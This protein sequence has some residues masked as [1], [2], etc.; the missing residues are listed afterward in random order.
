MP[1]TPRIPSLL[2][3]MSLFSATACSAA[4]SDDT[5]RPL[6]SAGDSSTGSGPDSASEAGR[7]DTTTQASETGNSNDDMPPRVEIESPMA[8]GFVSSRVVHI[9]G[10]AEDDEALAEV[11]LRV[12]DSPWQAVSVDANAQWSTAITLSRG[13]HRVQVVARDTH[14]NE[15]LA[16]VDLGLGS[17]VAGGGAHSLAVDEDGVVWAWG[18]HNEGQ[19]G[20]GDAGDQTRPVPVPGLENVVS[21][22]ANLN[23]SVALTDTGAVFVWGSND[24]SQLG[25]EGQGDQLRPTALEMLSNI[26]LI[27]A[28]QR[29]TVAVDAEGGV[30]AWGSNE[31][32]QLGVA[33]ITFAPAPVQIE[34]LPPVI[35]I[36]AGAGHTIAVAQDGAVWTW[37]R[38]DDGQLARDASEP[39]AVAGLVATNVAAGKSHSLALAQAGRAWGWGLQS[40]GQV[41]NGEAD[42]GGIVRPTSLVGLDA[43]AGVS[44][45]GNSS[46]ALDGTGVLWAWGDN[47]SGQLGVGDRADRFEPTAVQIPAPVVAVDQGIAHTVARDAQGGVWAWGLNSFGQVGSGDSGN[48]HDVPVRIELR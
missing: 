23:H 43:V 38:G 7:D 46:A 45:S 20:T 5:I 22:A 29:H 24:E 33:G 10:T 35:A 1:M 9:V 14:G 32:G 4:G 47:F 27:A 30:W 26:D 48:E 28:G 25:L 2:T 16:S 19:L 3:M 12:D 18:R 11:E 39:G 44:A 15:T 36:A 37:G 13:A 21:L 41:G 34:A 6:S 42:R 8:G 17:P 31:H 40:L